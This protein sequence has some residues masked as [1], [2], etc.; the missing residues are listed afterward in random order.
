MMNNWDLIKLSLQRL[1]EYE[2][3]LKEKLLLEDSFIC[4]HG[5]KIV[6]LINSLFVSCLI[7]TFFGIFH[8]EYMLAS[9]F[10]ILAIVLLSSSMVMN[11][12]I[13]EK[14]YEFKEQFSREQEQ[15]GFEIDR[16]GI[17][18]NQIEAYNSILSEEIEE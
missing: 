17:Y 1:H 4:K 9:C 11:G 2:N 15:M 3:S 14:E 12:R 16:L 7:Q 8:H 5:N 18:I 13:R 6:G 10:S